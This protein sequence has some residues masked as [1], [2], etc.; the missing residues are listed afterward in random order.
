[1][2]ETL[3]GPTPAAERARTALAAAE[4]LVQITERAV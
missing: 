2:R 1:L 4:R 3:H